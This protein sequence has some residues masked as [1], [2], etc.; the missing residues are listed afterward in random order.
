MKDKYAVVLDH[1]SKDYIIHHEK[2]TLVERILKGKNEKFRALKNVNL[3][4]KKGDVLGIV[5]PNGS[6]KSTLLKIISG[7][8][9]PTRG[10]VTT[11][12]NI[13]SLIDLEAG[14]HPDLTGLQNIYVNSLLLGLSKPHI[15]S[16][17]KNIISFADIG[18]FMDAPLFTYSEGMKL[19]LGFSIMAFS[20]PD[21]LL[22]DESFLVGDETFQ[23]RAA[24]KIMEFKNDGVAIII[25]SHWLDFIK[26]N[27]QRVVIMNKGSIKAVGGLSLIDKYKRSF[28]SKGDQ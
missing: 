13:R 21:I 10:R 23:K 27:C 15:D 1:I 7:I 4:I 25:V 26:A 11:C 8:T 18:N 9:S 28:E 24:D 6:G 2:P 3:K 14:F 12:G 17:L 22:L 5:G 19:R 16:M 20:N